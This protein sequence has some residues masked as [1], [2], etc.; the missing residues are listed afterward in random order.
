MTKQNKI[1]YDYILN[2]QSKEKFL[3]H[4]F[5]WGGLEC[6]YTIT[7]K[8]KTTFCNC[9]SGRY[10]RYCKHKTWVGDFL[11]GKKLPEEVEIAIGAEQGI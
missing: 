2:E 4:K 7:K 6:T 8:N 9:P 1:K 11:K 10:R 3:V 5:F